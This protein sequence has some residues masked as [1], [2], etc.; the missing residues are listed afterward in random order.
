MMMNSAKCDQPQRI[1]RFAGRTVFTAAR[2]E[3]EAGRSGKLRG[4]EFVKTFPLRLGRF[5]QVKGPI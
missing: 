4:R 3:Y 2:R 5:A 1:A